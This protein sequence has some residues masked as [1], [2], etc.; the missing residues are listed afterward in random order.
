MFTFIKNLES[1]S[2]LFL[3]TWIFQIRGLM[4]KILIFFIF[5]LINI[6]VIYC[7]TSEEHYTRG[8]S[9]LGNNM[10]D[11]AIEEFKKSIELDPNFSDPHAR[12]GVAY[13]RKGMLNEALLQFNQSI[14]LNPS[15]F[16]AFTYMGIIYR[17]KN[18]TDKSII[19]LKKAIEINPLYITAVYNLGTAYLN[20]GE[21]DRAIEYY[22]EVINID[23][24]YVRVYFRLAQVYYI[25]KQ[26]SLSWANVYKAR[27]LGFKVSEKFIE[28]LKNSSQEPK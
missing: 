7:Q 15:D 27:E 2:F 12:L 11:E 8:E 1:R 21:L 5:L 28:R 17:R 20:K 23:S 6:N 22:N 24:T 4:K 25:T 13:L 26:Y 3:K 16:E 18:M 9:Y 10:L 19:M 14:V